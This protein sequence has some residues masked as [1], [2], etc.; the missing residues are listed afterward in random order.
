M[1]FKSFR[2]NIIEQENESLKNFYVFLYYFIF[3][4]A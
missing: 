4:E 1:A 3:F 2:K